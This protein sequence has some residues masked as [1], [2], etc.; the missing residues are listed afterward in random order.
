MKI[1]FTDKRR[2]DVDVTVVLRKEADFKPITG[3]ELDG[4]CDRCGGPIVIN[5]ESLAIAP[6]AVI[7]CSVCILEF[8]V[9]EGVVV[10]TAVVDWLKRKP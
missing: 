8:P 4:T 3:R 1:E 2:H 7:V 9:P 5:P 6:H 10:P